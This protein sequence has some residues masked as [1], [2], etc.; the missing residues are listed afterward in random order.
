MGISSYFN[1]KTIYAL[2]SIFLESVYASSSHSLLLFSVIS[3]LTRGIPRR[4]QKFRGFRQSPRIKYAIHASVTS[5]AYRWICFWRGN[6]E[7]KMFIVEENLSYWLDCRDPIPVLP[8]KP[9][10]LLD[11][12]RYFQICARRHAFHPRLAHALSKRERMGMSS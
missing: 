8:R 2:N 9:L 10:V 11:S 1:F 12:P 4:K 6:V 3:F 5:C 7:L